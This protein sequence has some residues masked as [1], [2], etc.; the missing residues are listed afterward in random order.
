MYQT[1]VT[2]LSSV[3]KIPNSSLFIPLRIII[4]YIILSGTAPTLQAQ[5]GTGLPVW[6]LAVESIGNAQSVDWRSTPPVIQD[7]PNTAPSQIAGGGAA[8]DGCGNLVFFALHTGVANVPNNLFIYAANGTPLLTNST[9]NAPGLNGQRAAN[10]LTVVKVPGYHN[11]WFIIYSIFKSNTGAPNNNGGYSPAQQLFSRVRYDNQGLSVLVR[12]S[13]LTANGTAYT[14]THGKAVSRTA[15]NP[16]EHYLYLCRRSANYNQI[17]LDRFIIHPNG[18]TFS[19]NTGNV[20]AGW[21]YLCISG[22]YIELSPSEDRVAVINRNEDYNYPD[23]ILFNTQ[24]FSNTT[25]AYQIVKMRDLIL[26]PDGI[27]QLTAQ[28][29]HQTSLN[30]PS[31]EFLKNL[32]RKVASIEFSPSGRYLYFGTGGWYNSGYSHTT[33]LGQ[34]DLGPATQPATYP[35]DVRLQIQPPA[36]TMNMT[37]G[38]GMSGS[39]AGTSWKPIRQL[40]SCFDGRIYFTKSNSD[41]LY[42][43]PFPDSPM[44]QQLVPGWVDLSDQNNPNIAIPGMVYILPESID[45]LDYM[46]QNPDLVNL[47]PDTFLCQ[48]DSLLLDAFLP[49]ANYT[50]QDSTSLPTYTVTQSGTY[51]VEVEVDSCFDYDTI[52]VVMMPAPQLELGNDTILCDGDTLWMNATWPGAT[53]VWQDASVDSVMTGVQAGLYWVEVSLGSC[54][55]RDSL[56]LQHFPLIPLDLGPDTAVCTG[57]TLLLDAGMAG[58]TYA[59]ENGYTGAL[60]E[61]T[62]AGLY[63]V[64]VSQNTCQATD[65]IWVNL[66]PVPEVDLGADTQLCAN[67]V[68]ELNAAWP[69]AT[70]LWQNGHTDSILIATQAGVYTV[71]VSLGPCTA[72]DDKVIGH[73]PLPVFSLGADT[74]LCQG[75]SLHLDA[76]YPGATY[77]WQDGSQG[78]TYTVYQAGN[79]HLRITLNACST[80]DTISISIH[81]APIVNLGNDTSVCQGE[82]M[83][84]NAAWPGAT[85]LWQDGSQDSVFQSNVAGMYWVEVSL[86]SCLAS[87][88]VHL[89]LRPLPVADLGPDQSICPGDTSMLNAQQAGATYLW[90]DGSTGANLA[91]TNA[92]MYW[93]EVELEECF[94]SDTILLQPLP[95]PSIDLGND[96]LI[97]EG[98]RLL[99]VAPDDFV[100]YLW[101]NG[102]SG[103]TLPVQ[104]AGIRWLEVFDGCYSVRDSIEIQMES[105]QCAIW[106]PNAFTPNGDGVNDNFEVKGDCVLAYQIR[107]FDRWGQQV[108]HSTD[109]EKAWDGYVDGRLCPMDVYAYRIDY[110]L[111]YPGIEEARTGMV[112]LLY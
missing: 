62:Q 46:G 103:N 108:Y 71:T 77:L 6:P 88:T 98:D 74:A 69:G 99:L 57:D 53:Y 40:Q 34:I 64:T 107:I 12:D 3:L 35:Y 56:Y 41:S 93:V 97:C 78:A 16:G 102:A 65:S 39:A 7:I 106:V 15:V 104:T 24:S 58:A 52:V 37:H 100:S 51:W 92:G 36:G 82:Q 79:Y 8:F 89:S 38:G 4:A 47:G 30:N 84:W 23:L 18:I 66:L 76:T 110:T 112:L 44:P 2:L 81:P 90:S 109:L 59:W 13:M 17:S 11:E 19:A 20:P 105:C 50:W 73:L 101:S 48:G 96:T 25:G 83:E 94:A 9:P 29:I 22:S 26:Q 61:I 1:A 60:R 111:Q 80:S 10:E 43:I 21:W 67:E 14:Y 87:D 49:G 55:A 70:Y 95:E 5:Y 42:V 72:S 45:G 32:E 85:Y 31:L 91:V 54:S 33:Y 68:L 63:H 28:S 86:G 75:D 27:V